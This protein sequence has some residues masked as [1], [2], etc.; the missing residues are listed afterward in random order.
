[1]ANSLAGYVTKFTN[2]LDETLLK[3]PCTSDLNMNQDLLG[4]MSGAGEI[5]IA[6]IA[7][8][9]LADHTRGGGFVRGKITTD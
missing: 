7:M 5:K 3:G 1:M 6:K 8:D 4:E 2:K 9:G